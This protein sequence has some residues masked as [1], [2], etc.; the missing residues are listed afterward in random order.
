MYIMLTGLYSN[1]LEIVNW[2][3]VRKVLPIKNWGG[4][5]EGRVVGSEVVYMDGEKD[6][7]LETPTEVVNNIGNSDT[8]GKEFTKEH[9]E[10]IDN[11][12]IM[13]HVEFL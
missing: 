11:K 12:S 6:L 10:F 4:T 5:E 8:S 1:E 9:Q 13:E 7:F 2:E 3:N